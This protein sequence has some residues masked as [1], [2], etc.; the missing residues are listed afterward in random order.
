M[1]CVFVM[2]GS[3]QVDRIHECY[4]DLLWETS[5]ACTKSPEAETAGEYD[6]DNEVKCYQHDHDSWR[7]RDLNRLIKRVSF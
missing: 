5:A 2:Q 6:A 3:P 7:L 4:V 1:L